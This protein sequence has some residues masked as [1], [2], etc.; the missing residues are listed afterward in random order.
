MCVGINKKFILI[1]RKHSRKFKESWLVCSKCRFWQWRIFAAKGKYLS[2]LYKTFSSPLDHQFM[3]K[4]GLRS[5]WHEHDWKNSQRVCLCLIHMMT[6]KH[7]DPIKPD[8]KF[9]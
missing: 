8:M 2:N 3:K 1:C 6:V 9:L 5:R 4:F 7:P